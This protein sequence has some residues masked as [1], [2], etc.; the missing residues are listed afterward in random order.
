MTACVRK[1]AGMCWITYAMESSTSFYVG[2][3][4]VDAN[5]IATAETIDCNVAF[6]LIRDGSKNTGHNVKE[7]CVA[8]KTYAVYN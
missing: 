3:N 6:V 7:P 5:N 2:I 8:L 4:N 1:E